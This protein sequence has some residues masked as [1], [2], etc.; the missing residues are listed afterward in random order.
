MRLSL[1]AFL[2]TGASAF[3]PAVRTRQSAMPLKNMAEDVGIPCEE[4][5][6]L[7][8]FPNLPPSIHPGVLS[9]QAMMDLL[10]HAKANGE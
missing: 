10:D 6:A 3:A 9:G 1:V 2:I 8:C 4:E 5:C 7:D